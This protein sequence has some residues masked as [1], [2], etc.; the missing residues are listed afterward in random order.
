MKQTLTLTA[1]VVIALAFSPRTAGA[2]FAVYD[3]ANYQRQM[4]NWLQ[5]HQQVL[6]AIKN[7]ETA[8]QMY[9]LMQIMSKNIPNMRAR[10]AANWAPWRYGSA[11]DVYGNT[12][13]WINGVN[14][15]LPSTV[16]GGYQNATNTLQ[17]YNPSDISAMQAP[18]RQQVESQYGSVELADGANQD[19]METIGAIRANA[20]ATTNSISNI[21]SDSLSSD[22]SLNTEVSVLNKVNATNVLALQNAQD[23]NK[24][25]VSILE[26]QTINAKQLR[27]AETEAINDD[28]YRRANVVPM[29]NQL[30]GSFG[31]QLANYRLP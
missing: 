17:T 8:A 24:L 5:A 23:T 12:T 13:P 20:A 15:G 31:S 27:D 7:L 4:M 2:Q 14:T 28:I 11:R 18:I 6:T 26:Q 3:A 10:Y 30:A 21:Q 16:L 1:A 25:L 22:P 19:A 29:S 9:Q